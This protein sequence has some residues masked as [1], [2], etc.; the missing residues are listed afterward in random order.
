M[1][2]GR[3]IYSFRCTYTLVFLDNSPAILWGGQPRSSAPS[4]VTCVLCFGLAKD[5]SHFQ[6]LGLS[7][8]LFM[9][10]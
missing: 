7:Y 8:P 9:I 2:P 4:S 5:E 3:Y 6:T 1:Y 10:Q